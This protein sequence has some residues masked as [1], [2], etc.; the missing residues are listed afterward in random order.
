VRMWEAKF[1]TQKV[2]LSRET[3]TNQAN[4]VSVSHSPRISVKGKVSEY[5][6]NKSMT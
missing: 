3:K 1:C 6:N 4:P 2:T 5:H